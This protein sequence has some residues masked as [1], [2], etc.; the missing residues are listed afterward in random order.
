[1]SISARFLEE[2]RNRIAL[3]DVIGRKVRLVRAGREFKACCPFH[4]EKTPSFTVSDDKQF[5]HCFG[6]GAHG[7]VVGFLMQH[8]NLSFPEAVEVL[9]QQAGM[10]VPRSSPEEAQKERASRDLYAL[11]DET[12]DY[13]QDCLY[14]PSNKN[15]LDYVL[16]RGLSPETLRAYRIGFSPA[17]SQSLLKHLKSKGFSFEEM[18]KAGVAKISDKTREPFSFFRERIMFPVADRRGRCVAFGGRVLPEHLRLPDR[19]GFTPPKYINSPDSPLFHKSRMLYGEA[20][21]R[22]DVANGGKLLV[23][24]GYMDVI[25]CADAG[26]KG[27]VAPMGTALTDEQ[28]SILW[29]ISSGPVKEPILCFDGDNAGRRAAERARDRIFPLL[30]PGHSVRI[31]FLPEGEDPDTLIRTRGTVSFLAI[32][33]QAMPLSEF[34]WFSMTSGRLFN[35]PEAQAGLKK[36]LLDQISRIAD[37]D[38]QQLYRQQVFSRFSQVFFNP[39][40]ARSLEKARGSSFPREPG[41]RNRNGPVLLKK[42]KK[43]LDHRKTLSSRILL[44][45]LLNHPHIYDDVEEAL[46][47]LHIE[48]GRLDLLRQKTLTLLY[49][50]PDTRSKELVSAL[51]NEGFSEEIN[52]ILSESIYVHASFSSPHAQPE[53]VAARWT[54]FWD[55]L[56]GEK[57]KSKI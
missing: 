46:G 2:L 23:V 36:E 48:D 3:S 12:T 45:A 56:A 14:Q 54:A 24:E 16:G 26:F 4:G 10:Q 49:E 9:A 27:A 55:D 38:V 51:R 7:D 15:A 30:H 42:P 8:D 47:R 13:F 33:E 31:A 18:V 32:L 11:M 41:R 44:A 21:A 28:I 25:A 35:T 50:S 34:L 53:T 19:G 29:R 22:M 43:P 52:N 37:R 1:M 6:C 5:Y 57:R 17:D 40:S 20:H 39:G